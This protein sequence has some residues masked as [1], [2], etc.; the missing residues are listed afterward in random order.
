MSTT[1]YMETQWLC[2]VTIGQPIIWDEEKYNSCEDAYAAKDYSCKG[3]HHTHEDI[4]EYIEL[5]HQ[6]WKDEL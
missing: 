5:L 6:E 2:T 4:E 3:A 1:G